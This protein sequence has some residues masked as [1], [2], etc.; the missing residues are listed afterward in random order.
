MKI[1]PLEFRQALGQFPTGVTVISANLH[2]DKPL[3][4]TVNSFSSVSLEPPLVLWSLQKDSDNYAGFE[5][6]DVF[7]INV[8]AQTQ[9]AMS[10]TCAQKGGY[11]FNSDEYR[12]GDSGV[13]LLHNAVVS[14]ECRVEN[15]FDGGDHSIIVGRVLSMTKPLNAKP[16]LF[17]AG[18]YGELADKTEG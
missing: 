15:W 5:K 18:E 16:L 1:D 3:G 9:Q 14:F 10:M 11:A 7:S 17:H 13:A 8:L 12:L 2:G 4:I 6:T